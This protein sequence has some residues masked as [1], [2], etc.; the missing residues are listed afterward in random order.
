M[1]IGFAGWMM[2]ANTAAQHYSNKQNRGNADRQMNFQ[3]EMSNTAVQRR[4]EDMKKAGINPILAGKY[5]AST[6]AGAMAVNQNIAAPGSQA[7]SNVTTA[8]ATADLKEVQTKIQEN[9][10]A[11]AA[12]FKNMWDNSGK[13]FAEWMKTVSWEDIGNAMAKST[14]VAVDKIIKYL[15]GNY[16]TPEKAIEGEG[17]SP[18]HQEFKDNQGHSAY[19]GKIQR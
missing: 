15:Q 8:Q 10:A 14:G 18:E 6:P 3:R 5:D 16:D 2:A 11:I 19:R 4:M 17:L 12:D 7:Y 9:I 1:P 13:L